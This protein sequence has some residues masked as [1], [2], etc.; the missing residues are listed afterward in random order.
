MADLGPRT[1]PAAHRPRI[2]A[3]ITAD[4]VVLTIRDDQLKV[5]LV[6]R[7]NEPYRGKLAL[8]GGFLRPGEDLEQTAR[9]ELAEETGLDATRLT[10]LQL[11][12][13][14]TPDRDPR[15]RVVTTAF[16]IIAPNLPTPVA[17]TDARS[18]DWVE[19][20]G[21]LRDQ[22]AFDHWDILHDAM[23]KVRSEI[24]FTSLATA[25]CPE[26]FTIPELRRVFELLWGVSIDPGNF[27]RKVV[28]GIRGFIERT[29][30]KRQNPDGGRPADLYRRGP[31]KTLHPPILPP[32]RYNGRQLS[33]AQQRH[34]R[35]EL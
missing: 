32:T 13:Y 34:F 14:S 22:L 33:Q 24:E 20:E 1:P 10:M 5:L 7:G 30:D 27:R 2:D 35:L 18:A 28:E 4:L 11:H 26:T 15:G 25:F 21:S 31:A 19:A 3:K 16:L 9:R 12:T 6:V 23:E 29:S 17:R 8:P